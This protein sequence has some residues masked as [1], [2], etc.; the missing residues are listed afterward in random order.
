MNYS[1]SIPCLYCDT[2][3]PRHLAFQHTCPTCRKRNEQLDPLWF[4]AEWHRA[5][6]P[7]YTKF[8][9]NSKVLNQALSIETDE[10]DF[11]E[12]DVVESAWLAKVRHQNVYQAVATLYVTKGLGCRRIKKELDEAGVQPKVNLATVKRYLVFVKKAAEGHNPG[13]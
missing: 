1:V 7:D 5:L 6:L 9:H 2:P 11:C 4:D 3:T 12:E 10:I 8:V 13:L